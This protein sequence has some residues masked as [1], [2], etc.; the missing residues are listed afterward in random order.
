MG[1]YL[2]MIHQSGCPSSN[3]IKFDK[4]DSKSE[5]GRALVEAGQLVSVLEGAKPINKSSKQDKG[6]SEMVRYYKINTNSGGIEAKLQEADREVRE[7][8]EKEKR[9]SEEG[10]CWWRPG[11]WPTCWRRPRPTTRLASR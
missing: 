4:V 7:L 1:L 5:E 6:F 11:S 3:C 2:Y 8:R 9:E 10:A